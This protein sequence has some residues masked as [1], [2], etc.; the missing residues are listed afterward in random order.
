MNATKAIRRLGFVSGILGGCAGLSLSFLQVRDMYHRGSQHEAFQ[1]LVL[2][3]LIQK[4][5]ANVRAVA[6][7]PPPESTLNPLHKETPTMTPMPP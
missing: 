2:S 6:S 5:I 3:P 7:A 1:N 4:E